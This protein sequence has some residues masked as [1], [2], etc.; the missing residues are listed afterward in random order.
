MTNYERIKNMSLEEIANMLMCPDECG[1]SEMEC[2]AMSDPKF[3]YFY[4]RSKAL[5]CSECI[6]RWLMQEVT[7]G[8]WI[9]VCP[10]DR[11]DGNFR[12]SNCLDC[13]DIA[14]GEET[15]IERGFLFCPNC[16]AKMCEED[17]E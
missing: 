15:P 10:G 7:N 5:N 1:I 11:N 2:H 9:K 13:I 6:K 12:C 4:Y 16:G 17:K 8:S 14:T 3:G